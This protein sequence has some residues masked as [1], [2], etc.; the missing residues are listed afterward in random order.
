MQTSNAE[1]RTPNIEVN[2]EY[3][4]DQVITFIF[5]I[6]SAF[7]IRCSVFDVCIF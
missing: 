2:T 7:D 1:Y 6:A 4:R 3:R 5:H